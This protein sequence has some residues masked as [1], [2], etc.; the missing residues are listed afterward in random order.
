MFDKAVRLAKCLKQQTTEKVIVQDEPCNDAPCRG[1]EA[2]EACSFLGLR[3]F[4]VSK[5]TGKLLHGPYFPST[6][7]SS[8][9]QRLKSLCF[10]TKPPTKKSPSYAMNKIKS[11]FHN[12]LVKQKGALS[13]NGLNTPIR[14]ENPEGYRHFCDSCYNSLF[15]YHFVCST[16]A[17]EICPDCYDKFTT[18]TSD[19]PLFDCVKGDTHV[20]EEFVVVSKLPED[21]MEELIQATDS[22]YTNQPNNQQPSSSDINNTSSRA[23]IQLNNAYQYEHINQP[24]NQ[25][26]NNSNNTFSSADIQCTNDNKKDTNKSSFTVNNVYQNEPTS[27][28]IP[29]RIHNYNTRS[30]QSSQQVDTYHSSQQVDTQ[31]AHI[32]SYHSS[33]QVGTSNTHTNA[34]LSIQQIEALYDSNTNVHIYPQ[35]TQ[36]NSIPDEMDIDT[37]EFGTGNQFEPC[38]INDIKIIHTGNSGTFALPSALGSTKFEDCQASHSDNGLVKLPPELFY[39]NLF[40]NQQAASSSSRKRPPQGDF[41]SS[42]MVRR[43]R[44]GI[45]NNY[46]SYHYSDTAR[47][48]LYMNMISQHNNYDQV[49]SPPPTLQPI[50]FIPP[51]PYFPVP[52]IH[53]VYPE[54]QPYH[55]LSDSQDRELYNGFY[56]YT[57]PNVASRVIK[58][59]KP[60]RPLPHQAPGHVP[61]SPTSVS[62]QAPILSPVPTSSS[63]S[64]TPTLSQTPQPSQPAASMLHISARDLTPESFNAHWQTHQP[65]MVSESTTG[66][67]MNWTPEM[68]ENLCAQETL[69]ATD[70]DG[71]KF[72]VSGKDYFAAFSDRAKR[73][74][75]CSALNSTQVLKVKD[76][77]PNKSL[78]AEYPRLY[79]DFMNTLVTPE[80]C[81]ADGYFNLANRLPEEYLPPDLG[82]KLFI[83]YGSDESGKTGKTNLHCDMTDAVNVMY[84]ADDNTSESVPV[85]SALWH[86]FPYESFEKV[87]SYI[88]GHKEVGPLHPILDH[89]FYLDAEDLKALERKYD[90]VPFTLYQNPGDTVYIPAGCAHQVT[91]YSNSIKCAYDFIS[92]ENVDRSVYI[93]ECF[94]HLKKEDKLQIATTL[95]FAWTSLKA[96]QV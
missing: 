77:P 96:D 80:Y 36:T 60:R 7:N 38:Y 89:A 52:S 62:P 56:G 15:N 27:T 48:N 70:L 37:L 88:A 50:H 67:R 94:R 11:T 83:S 72:E 39:K 45:N 82:P 61:P 76:L 54:L 75:L 63:L 87:C 46:F 66:S 28:P 95:A 93:S 2:E 34:P 74:E 78:K 18:L 24:H 6:N 59:P 26:P 1:C 3:G 19:D 79:Q 40:F 5:K 90:V 68:F 35:Q 14:R 22:K 29:G 9:L 8:P 84:Y 49:L 10:N 47:C 16:C 4:K 85:A 92:P 33:Q 44:R 91:N 31:N 73:K 58:T 43:K 30:Y 69:E 81:T 86:I 51:M 42:S 71:T 21:E 23:N 25:Q 65:A 41:C 17:L 57:R 55:M 64:A 12:I 20:K 53:Y 13:K 32:N